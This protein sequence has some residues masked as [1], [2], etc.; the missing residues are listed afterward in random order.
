MKDKKV[1]IKLITRTAIFGALSIILYMVPGLQFSLPFA[2]SFLKIH[3][4]E[5][6]I[7]LAGF[8]F[9]TPT[10][11]TLLIIKSVF[12]LITDI[13]ATLGIGV[14]ADFIYGCALILPATL[15]YNKHRTFTG[16]TIGIL[17]GLIA[18]LIVSCLISLYTIFP[19]YGLVFGENVIVG[20][21]QVFDNSITSLTDIK[22]AYEFLLPFNFIK[23]SLV[24][25]VTLIIYK[26]TRF[27]ID[28]IDKK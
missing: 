1:V 19:L 11:I 8:A 9:G 16:V 25:F 27:L 21:F 4:E 20:M 26:P 13:P 17:V 6:P 15:I 3:L 2:P 12:K 23:D 14:L 7:L 5:I 18:N 24:I 28:K 22:I 10:A